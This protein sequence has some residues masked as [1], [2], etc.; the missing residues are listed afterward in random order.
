MGNVSIGLISHIGPTAQFSHIEG[1][2]V[3][4]FPKPK[5][6]RSQ[7]ISVVGEE[8]LKTRAGHIGRLICL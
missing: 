3:V 4:L 1:F 8:F 7:K 2:L 5:V 6:A